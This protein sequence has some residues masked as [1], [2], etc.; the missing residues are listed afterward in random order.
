MEKQ[1]R[2]FKLSFLDKDQNEIIDPIIL[3]YKKNQCKQVVK[4][5]FNMNYT[6]PGLHKISIINN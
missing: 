3:F 2:S 6:I 5:I 1:T 4:H